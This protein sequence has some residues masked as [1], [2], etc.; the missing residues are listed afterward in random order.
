MENPPMGM[1]QASQSFRARRPS[2]AVFRSLRGD[3]ELVDPLAAIFVDINIALGIDGDAVSLVEL[4]R[5]APGAAE[6]RQL[7]AAMAIDDVDRCIVLVDDEDELLCLIGREVDCHH[8]ASALLDRAGFWRS[9][10]CPRQ[11]E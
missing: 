10:G 5:E 6:T 11:I 3:F 2:R 4:T 8:R 7:L 1:V 9:D